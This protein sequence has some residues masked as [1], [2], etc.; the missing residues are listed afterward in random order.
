M[1][2]T[3]LI[4]GVFFGIL[5]ATT[6]AVLDQRLREDLAFALE[7]IGAQIEEKEGVLIYEDETPILPDISYFIME[8]NGSELFSHGM[9]ISCFD[10]DSIREGEYTQT[11][12][13]GE[14]W[15]LLDA[16]PYSFAGETVRV[17]TAV[18]CVE[19]QRML[20][21]M[22]ILFLIGLP[23]LAGV[24]AL[25]GSLYARHSLNPVRQIILC[26]QEISNGNYARRIPSVPAQD[27]LG[28]LTHTLNQ[29]LD[30]QEKSLR[31][32]RQFTSDASHE[33]RTPVA[34]IAAATENML[35]DR[36]MRKEHTESLKAIL[37]EC[38]RMQHMIEQMLTLTRGQE[39]R[40][41]LLKEELL[42]S[43]VIEGIQSVFFDALEQNHMIVQC[44]LPAEMT[45]YADQSLLTRLMLNLI[46]NAI[47]YG[48]SGGHIICRA[49]AHHEY[50]E[51][52]IQDDGIGI[53]AD[54][55]P[56]VF[57]R[58]Y[59]A[60]T[61]RNRSGTGLGLSIARWIVNAHHGQIHIKSVLEKGT[62]LTIQIPKKNTANAD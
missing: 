62:I 38:H 2:S 49:R 23:V 50:D 41:S 5:Y 53:S 15:L 48:K 30:A 54:D 8:E 28:E 55:V 47:K 43:D 59:R 14:T 35:T 36:E 21:T 32:E 29:M 13:N 19:N 18:S 61:A 58:F 57:D 1:L 3:A 37:A 6:A 42:L 10:G 26:A 27:E 20:R 45:V 34:V 46:E 44:D 7:Q 17:R 60:D 11:V 4:V 51:I 33:L 16:Y 40:Y 39:G 24:A 12:Y 56:R 31:R 9:D 25:V 22:R 52:I